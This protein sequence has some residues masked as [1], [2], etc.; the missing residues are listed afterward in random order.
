MQQYKKQFV[1]GLGTGRTRS[2]SLAATLNSLPKFNVVH[3]GNYDPNGMPIRLPWD[4]DLDQLDLVLEELRRRPEG[5]VGD[6]AM[7]FLPYVP[8]ILEKIP[9]A[10]FICLRRGK[11][12]VVNSFYRMVSGKNL[13]SSVVED[14]G[15]HDY[16]PK[17]PY[18]DTRHCLELY[19]EQYYQTAERFAQVYPENFYLVDVEEIDKYGFNQAVLKQI[20]YVV[21]ED[22]LMQHKNMTTSNLKLRM[23]VVQLLQRILPRR[24]YVSFVQLYR[25]VISR[26]D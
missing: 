12:E 2:T 22:I 18:P 7:W 24:L 17:Y 4:C 15:Y 13:W 25:K 5:W 10:K 6:V 8:A 11:D 3:E 21:A 23:K 19:W 1:F 16:F 9:G 26:K 14:D 20:G